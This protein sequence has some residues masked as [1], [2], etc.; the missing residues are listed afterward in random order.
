LDCRFWIGTISNQQSKIKNPMSGHSKWSTI[1]HKKA[2]AD[3]KR[4]KIFSKLAKEITVCA[5]D[6]G[7]DPGANITLR[8]LLQKA[9]A[10]NMPADNI[11]RAIKKGTG[12][13]AGAAMEEVMYEGY[14]IAGVAVIVHVLTDN[15]NR[16]AAEVRNVFN[17]HNATLAGQGSVTRSFQRRGLIYVRTSVIDEERLMEQAV[18][19]GAEDLS[20]EGDR[21]EIVTDPSD[22]PAVLD[23]LQ[24]GGIEIED[25][26]LSLV[27][28]NYIPVTDAALARSLLNFIEALEDL[29]DVQNVYTNFDIDDTLLESIADGK[30]E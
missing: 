17:K 6:G 22:Y 8:T 13:L 12:E 10:V 29:D 11:D 4:G 9:R 16:T 21:Y 14:A 28:D 30:P 25:S 24:T 27:P 19:A 1:K 26:E 18:E 3:A 5:R 20:R 2:A 7:G 23:A 15:R